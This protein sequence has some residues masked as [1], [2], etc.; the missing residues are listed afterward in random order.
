[1]KGEI[2]SRA[3]L[4]WRRHSSCLPFRNLL[5]FGNTANF[6]FQLMGQ[7][8]F[9]VHLASFEI[10]RLAPKNV[11]RCP[12]TEPDE[13]APKV[14]LTIWQTYLVPV[15]NTPNT[16]CQSTDKLRSPHR[17]SKDFRARHR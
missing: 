5:V 6:L 7:M 14:D 3:V 15:P 17:L 13:I 16:K 1:M 8:D 11:K 10:N 12:K 2:A 4:R 9:L